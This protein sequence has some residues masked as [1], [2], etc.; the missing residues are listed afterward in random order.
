MAA[1]GTP[2]VA[3]TQTV[4]AGANIWINKN[5][6]YSPVG[7]AGRGTNL[8]F[9]AAKNISVSGTISTNT[10]SSSSGTAIPAAGG[11]SLEAE[12]NLR[13]SS[14]ISAVGGNNTSSTFGG[15]GGAILLKGVGGITMLA[16]VSNSGG[17]S[18]GGVSFTGT[19]GSV[20]VQTDNTTQTSGGGVNDGQS[21]GIFNGLNL[22]KE[23]TGVFVIKG[24]NTYTGNTTVNA[25]TLRLGASESITN[26]GILT[27]NASGIFEMRDFNETVANIAGAGII[28]NGGAATSLLTMGSNNL[29]STYSGI[30]EDGS[31]IL[32]LTKNG[33]G[34]VTL[35]NANTYSGTT[36]INAG[37]ILA[38]NNTALGNAT[39]ATTVISGA[40]LQIQ[41]GV[42]IA[43]NISMNGTGLSSLGAIISKS[44]D[45]VLTGNVVTGTA[46]SSIRVEAGNLRLQGTT[47][48]GGNLTLGGAGT[49]L[50][51]AGDLVSTGTL[52]WDGAIAQTYAGRISGTANVQK[53][54]AGT[55]TL[56]A[57]NTYSGTMTVSAGTLV[58]QHNNALG[59]TSGA[60]TVNSGA[61]LVLDGGITIASEALA[62]NGAL[63]T[64]TGA[65]RSI[66]GANA[67]LG[68]ITTGGSSVY[69]N[70]ESDLSVAAISNP[71]ILTFGSATGAGN[72]VV[73]GLI[74]GVGSLEKT[75]ANRLTLN[76]ANT[77]SGL[78][79][80]TAG[81]IQLGIAQAVPVASAFY[82]NGGTLATNNYSNTLGTLFLTANSVLDLGTSSAHN[83]IFSAVSQL[84]DFKRLSIKGWQGDYS[85]QT[86]G[87]VGRVRFTSSVSTY[88]LDQILF[89]SPIPT[90]HYANMLTDGTFEIVPG[91]NMVI[92]P[93]SYS[94]VILSTATP[95][96]GVWSALVGGVHTFTPNADNAILNV[97]EVQAKLATG[98]VSVVTSNGS[99]TQSGAIIVTGALSVSNATVTARKLTMT[100]RGTVNVFAAMTLGST[101]AAV[102]YPGIEAYFESLT[103]DVTVSSLGS[104][105][106]SAGNLTTNVSA[107]RAGN[108]GNITLKGAGGIM[109][110]GALTAT[111][112]NNASTFTNSGGGNGGDITLIGPLG[113]TAN[114]NITSQAG[115]N[116][117]NAFPGILTVETDAL[118]DANGQNLGQTSTSVV[119]AGGFVKNGSGTFLLRNYSYGGFTTGGVANQTP[120]VSINS[121]TLKL[122][123]A[124]S[125]WDFADVSV[126]SGAVWDMGG[127]SETVGSIAGSG[128]IRNGSTLTL[129]YNNPS[130]TT[131]FSGLLEGG[132]A[133]VK[134][135]ATG[136]LELTSLNTYT[137][138]TTIGQGIIRVKHANGL[139]ATSSGTVVSDGASMQLDGGVTLAAEPIT[140]NGTG[141]GSGAL[142]NMT[143]TNT[144]TGAITLGT[145]AVRMNSD[146]GVLAISGSVANP[147]GLTFGGVANHEVSGSISGTSFVT[148]DGTGSLS[149]RGNNSYGGLTTVSL[150]KLFVE[151]A[152]AL[153]STSMGTTVNAG[154]SLQV[155]GGVTV[156][157]EPLTIN[158]SMLAG[159]GALA[160]TSGVNTW[161]GAV[162]LGST[163]T[164]SADADEL[165]ISGGIST[166]GFLLK[167][168]KTGGLGHVKMSGI[169]SGSGMLEKVGDGILTLS[170]A[171]TY[172]GFTK[173]TSGILA[174]GANEVIPN[175]SAFYFNGGTLRA[176]GFTETA[177][178]V[179][180][181][182]DSRVIFGSGVH[183]LTFSGPGTF[184]AGR[185]LQVN[186]WEGD[187]S[188][189]AGGQRPNV[190]D[191]GMLQTSSS[192]YVTLNGV[193]RSAGGINQFGQ[194]NFTGFPGTA[195]KLV[196][197]TRLAL[198]LLD[199][200]KFLNDA[201]NTLHFSVQLGSNE[202]VPDYTR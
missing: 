118:P 122:T 151:S 116:L 17:T 171:N 140:L 163:A 44:G 73:S 19:P 105:T 169:I 153:G 16:N 177:G 165:R 75:G 72:I 62:L 130:L 15:N 176:E 7:T 201:A 34:I 135:G 55:V 38:A 83:L 192:R 139:G 67:Y 202:I 187:F 24:A 53:S 46:A 184:T 159:D 108:A 157:A 21:A 188:I 123:S 78:T 138:L 100:A 86:S 152:N 132:L 124:T 189:P 13:I 45:N 164:V 20:I 137:G 2:S 113:I 79:R 145:P 166:A 59:S 194:I 117:T 190:E 106:T 183:R 69:L 185:T 133:L 158:G 120:L 48:M 58:L 82:F 85:N 126:A 81:T 154:A 77:Y 27:V 182:A 172:T 29:P 64:G 90:N 129:S 181:N 40:V 121:G 161:T 6:T 71:I 115:T 103:G 52:T 191:T 186:G 143:G 160:S 150:G 39:G 33:S 97:A 84:F 168:G 196:I 178:L 114:A 74:S 93:T 89:E 147:I 193:I 131:N 162:T 104:I 12:E 18:S 92:N 60:T 99:G 51:H 146:A 87:T 65:L 149:L 80:L 47:T 144:V 112:G 109:L 94:N 119:R 101:S 22:T 25:G 43:D 155:R 49:S 91:D 5:L 32:A 54:G 134:N 68:T 37:G 1:F 125:I 197:N 8:I 173:V 41:G 88:V 76:A 156:A 199:Q 96:N 107:S 180:L 110:N 148:K 102:A 42:Q 128:T 10:V 141:G 4:N 170:G 63:A 70:A 111:G 179:H 195:G 127:F 98:D 198:P 9:R 23:G 28:R 14:A 174:L 66:N 26:T 57:D 142:R 200:I 167:S 11:I 50:T 3:N 30:L 175:V 136:V 56:Q 36:L 61:G 95:S 31:G 35:S